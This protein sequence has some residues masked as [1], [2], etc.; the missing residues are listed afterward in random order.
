M[1]RRG[2]D[3]RAASEAKLVALG[4]TASE[5]FAIALLAEDERVSVA[6][7]VRRAVFGHKREGA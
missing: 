2:P 4:L 1:P 7:Y 6:E 3:K 5:A